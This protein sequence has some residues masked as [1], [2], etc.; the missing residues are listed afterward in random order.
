MLMMWCK[1]V[2]LICLC[3]PIESVHPSHFVVLTWCKYVVLMSV[4]PH[5]VCAS[6]SFVVLTWCKYV[7]LMSVRPHGVCA[8]LSYCRVNVVLNCRVNFLSC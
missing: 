4:R 6:L 7:V 1:F 8:S 2:M 3:V 5:G